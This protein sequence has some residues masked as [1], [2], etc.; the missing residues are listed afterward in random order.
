LGPTGV[1]F[2][3]LTKLLE[4]ILYSRYQPTIDDVEESRRLSISVSGRVKK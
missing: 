2:L 1:Y 4:R 3:R